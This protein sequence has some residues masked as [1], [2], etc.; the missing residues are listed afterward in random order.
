MFHAI[1]SLPSISLSI[2]KLIRIILTIANSL[3]VQCKAQMSL[4]SNYK[5]YKKKTNFL[6]I[7]QITFHC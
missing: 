2:S 1:I 3:E 5:S 4:Q 7:C 6:F